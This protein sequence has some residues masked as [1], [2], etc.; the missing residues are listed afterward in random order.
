V[1]N[2]GLVPPGRV[3]RT[4][5]GPIIGHDVFRMVLD[6]GAVVVRM[7]RLACMHEVAPLACQP[8]VNR[9]IRFMGGKHIPDDGRADIWDGSVVYPEQTGASAIRLSCA[10]ILLS[11]KMS[12][13]KEV[14]P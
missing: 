6:R 13:H 2:E 3:A 10:R 14:E 11:R 1:L 9:R 7:P 8:R 5:F 4:A 12:I